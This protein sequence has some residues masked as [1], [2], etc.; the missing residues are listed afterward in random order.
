MADEKDEKAPQ[1][2]IR[3]DRI[4]FV[5]ELIDKYQKPLIDQV[6][7]GRFDGD[8][9]E[10]DYAEGLIVETESTVIDIPGFIR[11]WKKKVISDDQFERAISVSPTEA[12]KILSENDFKKISTKKPGSKVL[13]PT[14][15][16]GV[17]IELVEAVK[18]LSDE[19]L[20][21]AKLGSAA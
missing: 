20:S 17:Q 11:L 1:R 10:G 4:I 12:Q 18:S 7:D 21:P 13:K 9:V 14:R 5:K 16:K 3:V 2:D 6:K 8:R 15:K 19:I